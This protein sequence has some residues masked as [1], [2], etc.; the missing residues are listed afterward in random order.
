MARTTYLNG[1]PIVLK[2]HNC[3]GC[4]VARVQG[5]IV[6]ERGC[7][8]AWRDQENECS[9]CGCDFQSVERGQKYCES[10][11]NALCGIEE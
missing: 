4:Q 7:P 9:E 11:M 6:H 3:N 10:C 8:D 2:G 5:T 1:D